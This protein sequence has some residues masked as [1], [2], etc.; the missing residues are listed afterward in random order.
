M[1][2]PYCPQDSEKVVHNYAHRLNNYVR[3]F[4]PFHRRMTA[5]LT[6]RDDQRKKKS[7]CTAVEHARVLQSPRAQ[8]VERA[9]VLQ[10]AQGLGAEKPDKAL[11]ERLHKNR[12]ILRH[13]GKTLGG[14]FVKNMSLSC[15]ARQQLTTWAFV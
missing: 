4:L 12:E 9:H 5:G 2:L 8:V 11:T 15:F 6:W 13:C 3:K 1:L 10:A 7:K 14:N